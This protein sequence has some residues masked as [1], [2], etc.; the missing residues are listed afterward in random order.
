MYLK[1]NVNVNYIKK[2]KMNKKFLHNMI[3]DKVSKFAVGLFLTFCLFAF[4]VTLNGQTPCVSYDGVDDG[5]PIGS[6]CSRLAMAI[7]ESTD[8]VTLQVVGVGYMRFDVG[9]FG[10]FYDDAK[11]SLSGPTF[12]ESFP[13]GVNIPATTFAGAITL[14]PAVVSAGLDLAEAQTRHREAGI[15]FN[16]N[17]SQ[18]DTM[19]EFSIGIHGTHETPSK[20][21]EIAEGAITPLFTVYLKKTTPG[22]NTFSLDDIGFGAFESMSFHFTPSW[23]CSGT[24]LTYIEVLGD[25]FVHDI[26]PL[27]FV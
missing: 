22:E 16:Q 15:T 27:I 9:E 2:R 1:Y 6:T 8:G 18:I 19:A 10:F 4:S 3:F 21:L 26:P 5:L 20:K 13:Y 25:D 17:Y 7:T 14:E 11:Y 24:T 12:T 23:S